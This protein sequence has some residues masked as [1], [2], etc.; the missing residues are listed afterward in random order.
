M[1]AVAFV[2]GATGFVGRAVVERLRPRVRTIAHVRPESRKQPEGEVARVPWEPAAMTA[3]VTGATHVFGLLGTTRKQAK[4]EQIAGDPYEAI[5]YGLTKLLIDAAVAAG[6]KPRFV[7]L[8]SVGVGPKA[9]TAYLRAHWKAEEA[10]RAS[11]LPWIVVRPSFIV[12]GDGGAK[13]DDGRPLE[14]VA[15]VAADGAL[16]IAGLFSGTLRAKY[17]S[18]TPERLADAIVRLALDGAP[19]RVYQGADL[20]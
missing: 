14:K 20:R 4:A 15:A 19:D 1:S 17:R 8:S 9:S 6:G 3:A 10:L 13:R 18:T 11:G 5:D 2:A 16:A 12:P 7:L